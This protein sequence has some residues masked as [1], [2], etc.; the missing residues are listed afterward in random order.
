MACG[1]PIGRRGEGSQRRLESSNR[2]HDRVCSNENLDSLE[3]PELLTGNGLLASN[4]VWN[5]RTFD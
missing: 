4:F 1:S 3:T 5:I 2:S